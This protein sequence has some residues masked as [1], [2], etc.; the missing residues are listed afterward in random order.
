MA[1]ARDGDSL[2]IEVSD[3]GIGISEEDRPRVFEEF[4]QV[5][6]TTHSGSG[7][8]LAVTKQIVEAQGGEVGVVSRLGHGSSF[9]ARLP[10]MDVDPAEAAIAAGRARVR[11]T[12]PFASAR[13][14]SAVRP[15]MVVT[16][17]VEQPGPEL[18]GPTR[19]DPF[20]R[21]RLRRE[22]AAV[23]AVE[24]AQEPIGAGG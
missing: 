8:G 7:L 12:T 6:S 19:S 15:L 18:P 13:P 14:I 10:W 9:Y 5:A 2:L 4:V 21:R 11:E 22:Q 1:L 24:R 20:R 16:S 17:R 3:T 23:V